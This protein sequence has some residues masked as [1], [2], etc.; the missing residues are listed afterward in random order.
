VD[1]L[2]LQ[3]ATERI[4]AA[5]ENRDPSRV[6]AA[7]E[8]SR[9]QVEAL[10]AAASVLEAELPERIHDAVADGFRRE[11]LPA[12]KQLAEIR[13]LLNN[14]TRRLERLEEDILAERHARIDDLA[15]LVDLVASGWRAVD[16]RLALMERDL[17]GSVPTGGEPSSSADG[18]G[19]IV[20]LA[21]SSAA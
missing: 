14:V 20:P 19:Q 11:V 6:D 3:R 9:T 15:L 12:G 17:A 5:R 21:A 4:A 16:E 10:A 8:R 2:K 13:G 18:N 7:L 1:E